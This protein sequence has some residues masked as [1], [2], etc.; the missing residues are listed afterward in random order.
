MYCV[1]LPYIA[2]LTERLCAVSLPFHQHHETYATVL[3][4]PS[5]WDSGCIRDNLD[6]DNSR[7]VDIIKTGGTDPGRD[8]NADWFEV[9]IRFIRRIC[10]EI[11]NCCEEYERGIRTGRP[12]SRS[13]L[14]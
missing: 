6:R 2:R 5:A 13:L 9:R 11:D 8:C 3:I 10:I 14:D 7:R 1:L 12:P 4:A